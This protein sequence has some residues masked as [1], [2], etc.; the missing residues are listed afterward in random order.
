I[1]DEVA[2]LYSETVRALIGPYTRLESNLS[3]DV[4]RASGVTAARAVL[5]AAPEGTRAAL[6]GGQSPDATF[7]Q[8]LDFVSTPGINSFLSFDPREDLEALTIPALA[9]FGGLD[10]Q[11]PPEQSVGPLAAALST[12]ESPTYTIVTFD[13]LN[14]LFQPTQTG[15]IEEYGRIETTVSEEVL[16]LVTRWIASL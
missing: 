9:V 7:E 14:H 11:V 2:T 1:P 5:D 6:L 8:L 4:R 16:S 10:L 13:R 3:D 15:R 12:S